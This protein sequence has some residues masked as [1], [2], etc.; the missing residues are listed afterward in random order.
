MFSSSLRF[1]NIC[2]V[3]ANIY[4]KI[5]KNKTKKIH[6]F[7]AKKNVIK[8]NGCFSGTKTIKLGQFSQL[9]CACWIFNNEFVQRFV[10]IKRETAPTQPDI[11]GTY[12]LSLFPSKRLFTIS[13]PIRSIPI[14]SQKESTFYA[15]TNCLTIKIHRFY[16]NFKC[17]PI[18]LVCNSVRKFK[19]AW[20]GVMLCHS[21]IIEKKKVQIKLKYSGKAKKK[22]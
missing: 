16:R 10:Q 17:I 2:L 22:Q 14:L 15:N 5:F 8:N 19:Y 18:C 3:F 7:G 13:A 21:F 4:G 9:Y 11:F 12:L 6:T 20:D 1:C